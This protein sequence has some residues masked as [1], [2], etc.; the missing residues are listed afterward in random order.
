MKISH[1]ID[2]YGFCPVTEPYER[3]RAIR[4]YSKLV[5]Q[6][7][8]L[9]EKREWLLKLKQLK[10]IERAEN[11]VLYFMYQ[12][13]SADMNP[14][15][16]DPLVPTG[17][18]LEDAPDFHRELTSML[19][20]VSG[21]EVNKR[22]AWASPRGSAKSAY[23]SNCFP[24]HQVVFQKRK[25][26]LIISETDSMSKKFIE[27]VANTLKFNELLREDFGELLSPK[28]VLNE[29]DNQEAFL[30]K[31][32][33]LVESASMGKQLRGK[34]NGSYRPDLVI[35]DDME[36][37]RNT[38]TVD[39]RDKN[40]HWFNSV[41]M[42]IGDP[43]RT[44]FIYMGTAVHQSGLLFEVMNRP[45]FQPKLFSAVINPPERLDLWDMFQ[46]ILQD[47]ENPDRKE[48]ALAFYEMNREEMDKGVKVL[49]EARFSYLQLMLEKASMT[50]K[51]FASEFLNNPI[52]ED[53][54]IFNTSNMMFWDYGD[55]DD[56]SLEIFG[57]WDM[58]FGKSNRADFNAVVIVGRER[59][60]GVLYILHTWAEKCPAHIALTKVIELIKEYNPKQ[61]AVETVQAQ[62]DLYRQLQ[63]KLAKEKAYFT[64][65][66]PI[67]TNRSHGKKEE[68]IEQL[69][70]LFE[71]GVIRPH[72]SQRLLLEQ[73]EMFPF[74]DYDDLPDS[75]QMAV[76]LCSLQSRKRWHK[77]PTGL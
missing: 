45:D 55:L 73:L 41:V 63:E 69:E 48:T 7:E 34:R 46:E 16:E 2:K 20:V 10:R 28:S 4:I 75:L 53:S 64:K 29:R 68:R 24:L 32:G 43:Q 13:L 57:S 25:Y 71:H 12:Y 40:L 14:N 30:T 3:Q 49:W 67:T 50:S 31:A 18:S 51:S 15:F 19:N 35:M 8:D 38:N 6:I 39:L 47:R 11:D 33:T 76:S 21:E 22:V 56:L 27:Y 70:P 62:F 65:L 37:Q 54:Q 5:M 59:K 9:K 1:H 52:D 44:G 77:K 58:A 23:L 61:F 17:V 60:T 74:A 72:K 36:S 26:I 42:P 66:K